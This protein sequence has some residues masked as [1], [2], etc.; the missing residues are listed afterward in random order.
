MCVAGLMISC[1]NDNESP[2]ITFSVDKE[3]LVFS[4]TG[5]EQFLSIIS[6]SK[7]TV[8]VNQDW[9]E[10]NVRSTDDILLKTVISVKCGVNDTGNSREGTITISNNKETIK[11]SVYQSAN[12]VILNY[13]EDSI[14][15][16]ANSL[17]IK[18]KY[19]YEPQITVPEQFNDW[20]KTEWKGDGNSSKSMKN[21]SIFV[22]ISSNEGDFREGYFY[23][24]E[25]KTRERFT[26][27]I[28]QK[29]APIILTDSIYSL[30]YTGGTFDVVFKI[31]GS[32]PSIHLSDKSW[33]SIEE[34]KKSSNNYIV[35]LKAVKNQTEKE[36]ASTL[37][38]E[39][40][41]Y[42]KDVLINQLPSPPL[43]TT[44]V[45]ATTNAALKLYDFMREQ[46]GQKVISS[47]MANVNWNNEIAE[48]VYRYRTAHVALQRPEGG[49]FHRRHLHTLGDH[50]PCAE[51]VHHWLMG[52]P[53]V[54]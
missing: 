3:E 16:S 7:P 17:E 19:E 31:N 23:V 44:P 36:R 54:L 32:D 38:I 24:M 9:I 50:L 41:G 26:I 28:K 30:A 15:Y 22:N 53:L 48:S 21:G 13:P 14:A 29:G 10:L 2:N 52:E 11:V 18:V 35:Q 51:C 49:G 12:L 20:I 47:V 33:L 42:K 6:P 40:E 43:S 4:K 1:S 25:E 5:G 34:T 8:L 27:N 46:Y 39:C 45:A 37:S